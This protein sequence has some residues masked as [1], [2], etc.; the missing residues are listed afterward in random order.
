MYIKMLSKTQ[1]G[2]M[3]KRGQANFTSNM[4][5]ILIALAV[6][7]GLAGTIFTSLNATALADAPSWVQTVV[8]IVVG[9]GFLYAIMRVTG[10]GKGR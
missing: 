7:G 2:K 4:I 10:V 9:A 8:P 1:L 3:Q 6:A 5:K